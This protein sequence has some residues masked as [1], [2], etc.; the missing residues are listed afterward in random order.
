M[1]INI[2]ENEWIQ[3]ILKNLSDKYTIRNEDGE[4]DSIMYID[5][6]KKPHYISLER[7]KKL[8]ETE[9]YGQ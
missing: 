4:L 6:N 3:H 5:D 7:L 8:I 9:G 2:E 1:T